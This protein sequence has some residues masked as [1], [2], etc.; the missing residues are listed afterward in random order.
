M[1]QH[2]LALPTRELSSFGYMP[3]VIGESG[4]QCFD[5]AGIFND[6]CCEGNFYTH[7]CFL[8]FVFF[9]SAKAGT[10]RGGIWC[11]GGYTNTGSGTG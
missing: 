9:F 10:G 6:A 1:K 11:T 3:A 4:I 8:L 7:Y 5:R 2:L